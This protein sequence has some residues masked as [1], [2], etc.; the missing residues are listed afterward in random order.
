MDSNATVGPLALL[1]IAKELLAAPP[2]QPP[3]PQPIV[4]RAAAIA[5]RGT[6]LQT[7]NKI[8][9][10]SPILTK[11]ISLKSINV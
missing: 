2:A 11:A 1:A 7:R 9:E 4:T 8:T 6:I 3:R 10:R 5:A